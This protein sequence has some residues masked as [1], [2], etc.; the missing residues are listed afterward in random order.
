MLGLQ[1]TPEGRALAQGR[2]V[3]LHRLAE[4]AVQPEVARQL[5]R[6]AHGDIGGGE[7]PRTEERRVALERSVDGAQAGAEPL[8][9]GKKHT[10]S[11]AATTMSPLSIHSKPQPTA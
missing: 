9:L 6:V 4:N 1:R 11:C 7:T 5:Q 8:L 3:A 2:P 10:R